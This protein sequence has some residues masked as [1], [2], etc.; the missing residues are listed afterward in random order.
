MSGEGRAEADLDRYYRL[1]LAQL[2]ALYTERERNA[3]SHAHDHHP[4]DEILVHMWLHWREAHALVDALED[5]HLDD[6]HRPGGKYPVTHA[7]G[8]PQRKASRRRGPEKPDEIVRRE[9]TRAE[10][11]TRLAGIASLDFGDDPDE[12]RRWLIAFDGDRF[13]PPLVR[14]L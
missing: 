3:W 9:M 2:E 10:I 11:L 4:M 1:H 8:P 5:S 7:K 13:F 14:G 6:D 12:W